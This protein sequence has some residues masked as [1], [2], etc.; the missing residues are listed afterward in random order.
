MERTQRRPT[1]VVV[2]QQQVVGKV[3][4]HFVHEVYQQ[5]ARLEVEIALDRS[6]FQLL[7][8]SNFENLGRSLPRNKHAKYAQNISLVETYPQ[9]IADQAVEKQAW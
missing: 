6:S 3:D 1:D 8:P 9:I 2:A 5:D 4:H 7:L